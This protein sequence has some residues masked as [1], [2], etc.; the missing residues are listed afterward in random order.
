MSD[1]PSSH[2]LQQQLQSWRQHAP[3]DSMAQADL[4]QLVMAA[5]QVYFAPGECILQPG[6]GAVQALLVVKSGLVSAEHG[7]AELAGGW[8][9]EAA[10]AFR[11]QPS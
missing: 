7:L 2:L 5:E 4:Q 10:T 6:D 1:T 8:Q 9:Y 3:F 11:W